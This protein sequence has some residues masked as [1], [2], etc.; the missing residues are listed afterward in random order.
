M[1]RCDTYIL[2][3]LRFKLLS[4]HF[5]QKSV[6]VSTVQWECIGVYVRVYVRIDLTHYFRRFVPQARAKIL[7]YYL[8]VMYYSC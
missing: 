7:Q 5:H 8:P 3:G 6:P 4:V 1:C 2:R